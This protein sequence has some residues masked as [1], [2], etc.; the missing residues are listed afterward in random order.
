M[1]DQEKVMKKLRMK[2]GEKWEM[3]VTYNKLMKI[4]PMGL[5]PVKL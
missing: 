3:T 2:E 1:M 5:I 4:G